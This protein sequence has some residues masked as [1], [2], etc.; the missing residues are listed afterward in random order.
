MAQPRGGA[1]GCPSTAV[2]LKQNAFV[3]T[4]VHL[5][6]STTAKSECSPGRRQG[7]ERWRTFGKLTVSNHRHCPCRPFQC[8]LGKGRRQSKQPS[9]IPQVLLMLGS[10]RSQENCYS[11]NYWV[12]GWD[13]AFTLKLRKMA[14]ESTAVQM[15]DYRHN[16]NTKSPAVSVSWISFSC[17]L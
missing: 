5:T 16:V 13:Q 3:V 14:V 12:N 7:H 17:G 4:E 2:S 6:P 9:W 15:N 1:N 10:D 8:L 11:S